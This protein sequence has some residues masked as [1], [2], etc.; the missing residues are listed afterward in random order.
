VDAP[1][2]R[3][4]GA[5]RTPGE[6]IELS[7]I[8]PTLDVTSDR[9]RRCI[10]AVQATTD[11][12]HEIVVIDNGAPPQGF[13]APVNAGLRAAGGAYAVVMN[14]D[15]EPLA[16]WWAP[17]RAA[18][19]E[20]TTVAFPLTV[21]GAMR[22]DFAAWCFALSAATLA[23]FAVAPGEFLDPQLVV[24][25]Q[26]TDLLERLRAAGRPP[27]CVPASRIRHGLSET[28]ESE[29]PALRAWIE[30]QVRLDKA[31]F[32]ALHPLRRAA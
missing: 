27:V 19:D 29:D 28:V 8:I 32:D 7:I 18:L 22:H 14:D 21:D 24:W 31:H 6:P 25:Y 16:G 4:G 26:D 5:R 20:G 1:G 2:A 10:A 23:E 11:C 15:V 9:V 12:A 17:L 3:T 30:R 13:S